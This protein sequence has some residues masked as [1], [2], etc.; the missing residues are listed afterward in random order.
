MKK[1]ET[2]L[3]LF[4][5]LCIL[6]SCPIHAKETQ[7]SWEKAEYVELLNEGETLNEEDYEE[8]ALYKT[9]ASGYDQSHDDDILTQLLNM[10][11]YIYVQD[12]GFTTENVI[13]EMS[14]LVNRHPELYFLGKGF[15]FSKDANGNITKIKPIYAY[16]KI[17]VSKMNGAIHSAVDNFYKEYDITFMSEPE[18]ILA[19]HDYLIS[20]ITYDKGNKNRFNIY[21][22]LVEKQCVCQGY[23]QAMEYLLTKTGVICGVATSD[24]AEHAWNVVKIGNHW[25]HSDPTWDDEYDYPGRAKH[26]ELLISN[27]TLLNSFSERKDYVC[28]IPDQTKIF[29]TPD[30]KTYEK[31]FWNESLSKMLYYKNKWYYGSDKDFQIISYQYDSKKKEVLYENEEDYWFDINSTVKTSLQAPVL[32]REEEMFY[33]SGPTTIY[34]MKLSNLNA[35][36]FYRPEEVYKNKEIYRLIYGLDIENGNLMYY[37][38]CSIDDEPVGYKAPFEHTHIFIEKEKEPAT[39]TKNGSIKYVCSVCGETKTENV[40]ATGHHNTEVRGKKEA[41][42][43]SNGYTGDVYCADCGEKIEE[44]TQLIRLSHTWDEG[45]IT[46]KADCM[47]T[48]IKTYTC[49]I[50]HE[51]RTEIVPASEHTWDSGRVTL[52][53]TTSSYGVKTFTCLNCHATKT[54][55]IA[56]FPLE[57][58]SQPSIPA[59]EIKNNKDISSDKKN[60]SSPIKKSNKTDKKTSVR[61]GMKVIYKKQGYQI[62]KA[63]KEVCFIQAKKN[64]PSV[65]IPDTIFV[66]GI[67]YKVTSIAKKAIKNN[68]KIKKVIIGKN[69][70]RIEANAFYQC[71]AIKKVIIK[72]SLLTKK[73]V[74]KKVFK[75]CGKKIRF[76]FPKKKKK[77]YRKLLG[78]HK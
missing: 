4:F 56:K 69:I 34:Q 41:T 25:Y 28:C 49:N 8:A 22:A 16:T 74:S 1:K 63:G 45:K 7:E 78:F 2:M 31:G 44:G 19:V 15:Y 52:N 40:A 17:E 27:N 12:Y 11:N 54:E 24:N 72:S 6:F 21:G 29:S 50:C 33:F 18:K 59:D 14:K 3:S 39:C 62:T 76:Q 23:A 48:G 35:K 38:G 43:K 57:D 10:E 5:L 46:K 42:C 60:T 30:D 71:P 13:G 67:R 70:K 66:N 75:S 68:K 64:V 47:H 32:A 37:I 58:K 77:M 51:E 20:S 9:Y 53:P 73:N 61:V 55:E 26:D 65:N 36:A